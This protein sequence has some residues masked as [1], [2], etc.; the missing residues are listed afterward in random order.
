[1][2]YCA[3]T[4][5]LQDL[6]ACSLDKLGNNTMYINSVVIKSFILKGIV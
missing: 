5:S 3:N 2:Y 1:M 4:E 6:N